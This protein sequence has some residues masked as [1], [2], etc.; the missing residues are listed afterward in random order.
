[1]KSHII[2]KLIL[3]RIGQNNN[4]GYYDI[5]NKKFG[6][7]SVSSDNSELVI[8]DF[9]SK[10]IFDYKYNDVDL[11]KLRSKLEDTYA[12]RIDRI[13]KSEQKD[14]EIDEAMKWDIIKYFTLQAFITA[15]NVKNNEDILIEEAQTVFN[16]NKN[17]F[18]TL[19]LTRDEF[20]ENTI[21]GIRQNIV[22]QK[23]LNEKVYDF[24][25]EKGSYYQ[26]AV[27]TNVFFKPIV[28]KLINNKPI[29]TDK[30]FRIV[31]VLDMQEYK[32][33]NKVSIKDELII[34]NELFK[35]S[36]MIIGP[37]DKDKMILLINKDYLKLF[38]IDQSLADFEIIE[39]Q[40]LEELLFKG[41]YLSAVIMK[42]QKP[43]KYYF[44]N[45]EHR[46]WVE[47]YLNLKSN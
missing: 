25:Q 14:P 2:S 27:I 22:G 36:N 45:Q 12:K 35:K 5:K 20:L 10:T 8:D 37:L 26:K 31:S 44:F 38:K 42:F 23:M 9:H 17:F 4:I 3:K 16:T 13:I 30:I 28:L 6:E 21:E 43:V 41:D 46:A 18:V 24:F 19:G 15:D 1:M 33:E 47:D 39:H 29:F 40:E 11:E 32:K 34:E 7:F